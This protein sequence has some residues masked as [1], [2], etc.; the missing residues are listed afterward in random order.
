MY[1]FQLFYKKG[2]VLTIRPV[3]QPYSFFLDYLCPSRLIEQG[4]RI[5][6]LSKMALPYPEGEVFFKRSA[7]KLP[8]GNY[9]YSA[10]EPEAFYTYV[11]V[12]QVWNTWA[13]S[14]NT[15]PSIKMMPG[16]KRAEHKTGTAGLYNT[17]FG[18]L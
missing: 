9:K 18:D 6:K 7:L 13:S 12:E 16:H 11:L 15:E 5:H 1:C 8:Q 14:N 10:D 2:F 3:S 4:L 17:E